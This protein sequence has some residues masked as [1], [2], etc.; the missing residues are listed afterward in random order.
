MDIPKPSPPL[1]SD[2][3]AIFVIRTPSIHSGKSGRMQR[4]MIDE[5]RQTV[6]KFESR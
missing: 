2:V 1:A 6:Y 5:K 4:N 3:C